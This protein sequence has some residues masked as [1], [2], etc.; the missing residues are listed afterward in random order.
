MGGGPS[1]ISQVGP[2]RRVS[3]E[4][5]SFVVGGEIWVDISPENLFAHNLVKGAICIGVGTLVKARRLGYFFHGRALLS[6]DGAGLSTEPDGLFVAFSSVRAGKVRWVKGSEAEIEVEGTPDMALEV[7]SKTSRRKDTKTL[8]KLYWEAGVLE[9]WLIDALKGQARFE[10]LE[11]AETGYVAAPL[12][13]DWQQSAVFG[14][15]FRLLTS[16]DELGHP[17][18]DLAIREG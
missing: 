3:R 6:N 12:E 10:I 2:L 14:R 9:Y 11:H 17:E 8:R 4:R 15:W 1:I 18:Y 16:R 7:V 13:D 5:P